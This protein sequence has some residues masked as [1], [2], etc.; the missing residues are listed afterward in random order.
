MIMA[1]TAVAPLPA[2]R[3]AIGSR[4]TGHEHA[5][6]ALGQLTEAAGSGS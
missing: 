3:T 2:A 6:A 5:V 4:R 1:H